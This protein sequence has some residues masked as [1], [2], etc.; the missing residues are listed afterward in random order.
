MIKYGLIVFVLILGFSS[1]GKKSD[2]ISYKIDLENVK[3]D[4]IKVI[5]ELPKL[6]QKDLSF[7]LPRVVP[8]TYRVHNYGSCLSSLVCF[9]SKEDSLQY[10]K[11]DKNSWLIS[12]SKDCKRIEYWID[13]T[14]D[15]KVKENILEAAGTSF[16]ENKFF[17]LNNFGIMGYFSGFEN[18]PCKLEILKPT[19]LYTSSSLENLGTEENI[20]LFHS[21]SYHQLIDNPILICAPDTATISI[22]NATILVSIYSTRKEKMAK[23]IVVYLKPLMEDQL[24]YLG[25]T[26][27]VEKYS[28]LITLAGSSG[29]GSS[30]GALEHS[31]SSFFYL[32]SD[33][34]GKSLESTIEHISAH[35]FLHIITPLNIHSEEIGDFDYQNPKMSKH[36][37][38]YEG[39]TEY[40]AHHSQL[41]GGSMTLKEYLGIQRSKIR[42]S[43][44]YKDTVSFTT[45]SEGVLGDYKSS[46]PNVYEKGAL[47]GLCLDIELRHLSNGE[48]GTRDLMRDLSNKYGAEKSFKDKNLFKDI[49]KLTYPEIEGFFTEY[50]SGTVPL[51]FERAFGL[52]G[53]TYTRKNYS[54]DLKIEDDDISKVQL[55]NSWMGISK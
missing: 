34:M 48:Y 33:M 43:S 13:D 16:E 8:G 52:I 50:V 36:L 42:K 21:R 32:P 4:K 38:M 53:I 5:I 22:G 29:F 2:T 46:Y 35:E 23:N 54:I 14:W 24:K 12:N 3:N 31:T 28:F 55:R 19:G 18:Y 27:P 44:Y 26:L 11:T 25:G 15:G 45:F 30:Y 37:W 10:Q 40:A 41:W 51:D 39:L 17:A 49:T 20:D 9:D 6:N 7:H 47:I 1:L